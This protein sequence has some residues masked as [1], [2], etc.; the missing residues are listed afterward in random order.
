MSRIGKTLEHVQ[1]LQQ[2]DAPGRWRRHRDD[3]ISAIGAAHRRANDRLIGF[4]IVQRHGPAGVADRLHQFFG[5]RPFV[6]SARTLL[7]NRRKRRR[8]IGL[9]KPVAL[10]Q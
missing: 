2:H 4:E 6:K 3:V 8:E 7:G 10:A 9:N 5:D 1:R